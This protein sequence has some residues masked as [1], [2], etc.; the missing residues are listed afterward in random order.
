MI[1]LT[2]NLTNDSL[3]SAFSTP[4][5]NF[6]LKKNLRS[7][8]AVGQFIC[9]MKSYFLM[10]LNILRL[11]LILLRTIALYKSPLSDRL[12][13]HPLY[14]IEKV[15]KQIKFLIIFLPL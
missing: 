2:I 9:L 4:S 5:L 10:Y 6:L 1:N 11:S 7:L 14:V 8:A 3:F 12:Y 15:F 13:D